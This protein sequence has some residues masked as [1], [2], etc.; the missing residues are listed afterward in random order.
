MPKSFRLYSEA[1]RTT[2]ASVSAFQTISTFATGAEAL[3]IDTNVILDCWVFADAAAQPLVKALADGRLLWV[4]TTAM[5]DELDAV[6]ERTLPPR[7]EAAR[8]QAKALPARSRATVVCTPQAS[9]LS[10]QCSDRADQK[11]VDLALA[12]RVRWLLSHDR[13]LLR[14]SRALRRTGIT[15]ATPA[16][17]LATTQAATPQ[18]AC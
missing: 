7:W 1:G 2:R 4:A 13:A 8:Q 10:P 17:W 9:V 3:V 15:V 18:T 14:L 12:L 11:F 5:L 16:T 6:L